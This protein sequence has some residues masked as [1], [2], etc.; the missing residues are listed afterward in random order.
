M[1]TLKIQ[2]HSGQTV[3]LNNSCNSTDGEDAF[4]TFFRRIGMSGLKDIKDA[5]ITFPS[6]EPC[7]LIE[8][9]LVCPTLMEM[10]EC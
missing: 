1:E 7:I 10:V 2:Y 8:N 4:V 9:G 3:I 6:Y 5:F